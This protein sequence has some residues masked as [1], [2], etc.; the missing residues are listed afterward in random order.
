MSQKNTEIMNAFKP[1]ETLWTPLTDEK[2]AIYCKHLQDYDIAV[3]QQAVELVAKK[4]DRLSFP[5]VGVIVAQCDALKT[6]AKTAGAWVFDG[7]NPWEKLD[8]D[9]KR[10]VDEYL[11]QFMHNTIADEARAGGWD[12]YLRK[13]V[14]IVAGAQAQLICK[15]P[16]GFSYSHEIIP[17]GLSAADTDTWLYG[18]TQDTKR[19]AATGFIEVAIPTGKI[20]EWRQRADREFMCAQ[21][22]MATMAKKYGTPLSQAVAQAAPNVP[23]PMPAALPP[24]IEGMNYVEGKNGGVYEE[25]FLP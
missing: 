17:E 8:K 3:I 18:F 20:L 16:W 23:P 6:P 11:A 22:A 13:Y 2:Y 19:Q 9:I 7:L 24:S 21:H 12:H 15:T 25:D 14:M 4:W 5:P 1:L 10:M